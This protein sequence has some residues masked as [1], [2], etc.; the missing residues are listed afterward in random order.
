MTALIALLGGTAAAGT[1]MTKAGARVAVNTSPEPFTN[2]FVSLAEDAF[3]IALSFIA[4]KY[5]L[6][7][8]ALSVVIL[9]VIALLI[10]KIWRWLRP[11]GSP[12]QPVENL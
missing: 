7:A 4:L 11:A 12:P 10:R 9:V 3:V 1:H 8:L 6:V 5:P 2:W